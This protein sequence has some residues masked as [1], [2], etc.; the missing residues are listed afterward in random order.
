MPAYIIVSLTPTD[1]EKLQQYGALV[2]P[3]LVAH[4]G[5]ILVKSPTESLHGNGEFAMQVILMFPSKENASAWYN[6]AEYQKLIPI[7]DAGMD[8]QFQLVG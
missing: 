4:G 5:E 1:K 3:T 2:P 8:S 6:S 7:R